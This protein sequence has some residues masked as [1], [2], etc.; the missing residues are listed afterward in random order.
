MK[1]LH[2]YSKSQLLSITATSI[3]IVIAILSWL[4][5]VNSQFS[6]LKFGIVNYVEKINLE[7]VPDSESI[8]IFYNDQAVSNLTY[9]KYRF[10]NNG[11]KPITSSDHVENLSILFPDT[12][13]ILKFNITPATIMSGNLVDKN[14]VIFDSKLLNP[15]DYFDLEITASGT[16]MPK[17]VKIN[18]RIIGVTDYSL[19]DFSTED[20][21]SNADKET[22]ARKTLEKVF[23]TLIIY[24]IALIFVWIFFWIMAKNKKIE[25][26][27]MI[28]IVVTTVSILLSYFG[29]SAY[30]TI[31]N[32]FFLH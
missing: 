9:A 15:G 11:S 28:V 30:I 24:G 6:S 7:D 8:K 16:F 32:A 31:K 13:T 4:F 5:P 23:W 17:N 12:I 20:L 22:A 27:V 26:I 29:Y 10:I 3:A 1:F 14:L 25:Q 19:S 2:N 21:M 18:G